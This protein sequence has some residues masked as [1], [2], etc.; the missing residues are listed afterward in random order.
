LVNVD[1][2]GF[3]KSQLLFFIGSI[4]VIL[5]GIYALLFYNP[6][7]KYRPFFWSIIFTLSIFIYFK[8]KD[9]YAIGIYPVYIA[10]G[11]VFLSNVLVGDWR[12]H[13]RPVLVLVPVLFFIPMYQ[14]TF[15][16][17]SPEHILA[18]QE[19]YRKFGLLRWEDGKD[20]P[21]PQDFADM[22]GWKELAYKVDS[23]YSLLPEP[24]KTLVLCDNYGQAGAI[25]YYTKKG[26]KASSFGADYV[27]WFNLDTRYTDLIRVKDHEDENE[28]E[29]ELKVSGPFF[30]T[31]LLADS[32]TNQNARE[33]GTRIFLFTGA[34]IDIRER[35]VNEILEVKNHR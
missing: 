30:Q 9:Y 3:L 19:K 20:H 4:I 8:A 22:L 10:F 14:V 32:I 12:K 13:L 27:N 34:K 17:K 11:S 7:Q 6:F 28:D 26:V 2:W 31:S 24:N 16:N 1:R 25:N 23:I 29:D 5:S 21:L 15:P 33:Y 18:H 35:I